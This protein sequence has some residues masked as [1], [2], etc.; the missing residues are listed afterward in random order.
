MRRKSRY[1]LITLAAYLLCVFAPAKGRAGGAGTRRTVNGHDP[2]ELM[3]RFEKW[4]RENGA[5]FDKVKPVWSEDWG[6]TLSLVKDCEPVLCWRECVSVRVRKPASCV[7]VC[8]RAYVHI[9]AVC[10]RTCASDCVRMFMHLCVLARGNE[11]ESARERASDR[12]RGGERARERERDVFAV[13]V[14]A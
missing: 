5:H 11:R 9:S 14:C 8:M 3:Q 2:A 13:C 10:V 6:F 12:E 7:C 4:L 1:A